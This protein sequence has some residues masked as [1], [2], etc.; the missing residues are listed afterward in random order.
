[1]EAAASTNSAPMSS[2]FGNTEGQMPAGD[3]WSSLAQQAPIPGPL[4]YMSG[5]APPGEGLMTEAWVAPVQ[6]YLNP[7][8]MDTDSET[9]S[10]TS[11]DDGQEILDGPDVSRMGEAEAA[12]A[13]LSQE[14]LVS[15]HWQASA[16]ISKTLQK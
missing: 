6:E 4:A 8:D 16:Q 1:M 10:D 11:P 12:E 5:P 15:I 9:D 7:G 3:P 13:I 2:F 14:N